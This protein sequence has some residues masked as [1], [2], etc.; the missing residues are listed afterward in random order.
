MVLR[1]KEQ[2]P[3]QRPHPLRW[4]NWEGPGQSKGVWLGG[5][6]PEDDALQVEG[7]LDD[8]CGGDAHPEHIL[9]GGKVAGVRDAVQIGEIAT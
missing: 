9:L 1:E 5:S 4:V 8:P 2:C 3:H 7:V 6:L